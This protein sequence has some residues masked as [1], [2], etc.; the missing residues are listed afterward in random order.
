MPIW[1]IVIEW[2]ARLVLFG[3]VGLSI[4]SIAIMLNRKKFFAQVDEEL[5]QINGDLKNKSAKEIAAA[6]GNDSLTG[7][8]AGALDSAPKNEVGIEKT[9]MVSQSELREDLDDGLLI[10]GTLGSTSPFIGLFGTVLGIIV[11]FG[12]LSIGQIDSKQVMY[13]LA[14]ALVLTAA[15]LLVAIPAV[16]A[17]NLFG[18][19]VKRHLANAQSISKTLMTYE[20]SKETSNA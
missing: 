20:K 12:S 9:A 18:R 4:W 17:Y 13:V 11:A 8:F 7:R 6:L 2:L 19:I 1:M 15:G 16:I 5:A 3:L 10:L 14:E